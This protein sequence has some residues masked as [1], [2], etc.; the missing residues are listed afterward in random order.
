MNNP[1]SIALLN[2][3]AAIHGEYWLF[4]TLRWRAKG[5]GYYSDSTLYDRIASA[6]Q[7]E[8][9]KLAEMIAAIGGSNLLNPVKAMQAATPFVESIEA[10]NMNDPQ[11]GL[12]ATQT[13]M[14]ALKEANNIAK[15]NPYSIA[16]QNALSQVSDAHLESVYLLQQRIN[17]KVSPPPTKPNAY[18]PY[19]EVEFVPPAGMLDIGEPDEEA[20][21]IFTMRQNSRENKAQRAPQILET[22]SGALSMLPS[23]AG[24]LN[25]AKSLGLGVLAG[26]MLLELSKKNRR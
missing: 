14:S 24:G 12:I 6:R 10:L 8:I 16:V 13:A 21:S 19:G 2:A 18:K 11:K 22:L 4:C 20:A 5:A 9:N 7:P 26:G 1:L 15:T 3:W 23:G 25:V 17:G